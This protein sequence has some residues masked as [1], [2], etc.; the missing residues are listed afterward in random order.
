M[1]TWT[2]SGWTAT[3][4]TT[5]SGTVDPGASNYFSEACPAASAVISW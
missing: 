3:A 5:L 1:L 2:C 4:G